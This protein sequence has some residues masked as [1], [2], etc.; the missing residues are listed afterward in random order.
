MVMPL[1]QDKVCQFTPKFLLVQFAAG[2]AGIFLLTLLSASRSVVHVDPL[3]E[4][5]KTPETCLDHMTR[6]YTD[7][8][9]SWLLNEPRPQNTFNLHF[10]STQFSRGDDLSEQRF[11]KLCLRHGSPYFIDSVCQKKLIPIGWHKQQ[12]SQYFQDPYVITIL[13]DPLSLKWYHRAAWYKRHGILD[14]KIHV[15][16]HDP[17]Y[18]PSRQEY[19]KKFNN[20]YL[21]DRHPIGFIK[22]EIIG[23]SDKILFSNAENFSDGISRIFVNLSDIL[24]QDKLVNV[25]NLITGR[26]Q[27]TP[28]SE[29][30]VRKAHFHWKHCHDSFMPKYS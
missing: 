12:I 8:C 28:I 19:I 25:V 30:F 5:N 10:I 22:K 16:Y 9:E 24:D 23:S 26:F 29:D 11:T 14:Q 6:C 17:A 18:N 21:F 13:I 3:V 15:K 1:T 2:S 20:Q 4:K 7:C 27:L